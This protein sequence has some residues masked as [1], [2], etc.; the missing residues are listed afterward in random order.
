VKLFTRF[1][2]FLLIYLIS[3]LSI[4]FSDSFGQTPIRSDDFE[5][6]TFPNTLNWLGNTDKFHIVDDNGNKRL[7]L[8]ADNTTTKSYIAL[9]DTII[10]GSLEFEVNFNFTGLSSSNRLNVYF[11]LNSTNPDDNPSGY[12]LQA[13]ESGTSDVFKLYKVTNGSFSL[14]GSDTTLINNGGIYKVKID[15]DTTNLI[16]VAVGRSSSGVLN[17]FI[18][19]KDSTFLHSGSTVF[20]VLYTSTRTTS[21][22][23]DSIVL[24]KYNPFLHSLETISTQE[25]LLNF[26]DNIQ[27]TGLSISDFPLNPGAIT[28]DNLSFEGKS[29]RLHYT[30]PLP[31][32]NLNLQ[33][34][35]VSD[36]YA[37]QSYQ[38]SFS[39]TNTAIYANG[40]LIIN[41][42]MHNPPSGLVDFVEIKNTSN[43]VLTIGNWIIRDNNSTP[44]RL[45][46]ESEILAHDF[47][48]L[49]ADTSSLFDR[50]GTR[51]Y[52]Q[53]SS[54]PGFNNTSKDQIRFYT[55]SAELVD[56]L[57]YEP[58]WGT[59]GYSLERRS[60]N[61]SAIYR[62]NWGPSPNTIL[63]GSPGLANEIEADET[64]PVFITVQALARDTVQ[65][66][67]T[68][69][70]IEP[71]VSD[72]N[73][74][75]ISDNKTISEVII[76]NS[77]TVK[78][79]LSSLLEIN[80]SYSITVNHL[81]DLFGNTISSPISYNFEFIKAEIAT[82]NEIAI[83]EF[84]YDT[85]TGYTEFIEL[86]NPSNKVFDLINFTYNDN[87]GTLKTI[88]SESFIF[89]PGTY[90][91][92]VPNVSMLGFFPDAKLINMGSS[93][94]SLNNTGDHIVI[95]NA[96]SDLI[97][98]LSYNSTWGGTKVSLER[99]DFSVLG[100]YKE[101]WGNSPN[102]LFASMGQQNEVLV[103]ETAPQFITRSLAAPDTLILTFNERLST[104]SAT[105]LTNY[106]I[107]QTIRI[108]SV[109]LAE[110]GTQVR[111]GLNQN[112][113][114]NTIYTGSIF[115]ISDVFGNSISSTIEF[116][117]EYIQTQATLPGDVQITEFMFDPPTGYSEFIELKNTSD[118]YLDIANWTFNDNSASPKTIS[119]EFR[120][121]KPEEF[122]VIAANDNLNAFFPSAPIISMGSNFASLNNTSD[123][124]VIKNALG[125][126][127]D[128][129]AYSSS[130]G[131]TKFSL[132]RRS[133]EVSSR[134]KENW[135]N[136]PSALFASPGGE[137]TIAQDEIA[138]QL[139]KAYVLSADSILLNF[140]ERLDQSSSQ[141]KSNFT[142][143]SSV[144][145]DTIR[146]DET[147]TILAIKLTNPL[148]ENSS[149]SGTLTGLK[150]IF[151]NAISEAITFTFEFVQTQQSTYGDILITEFMFDPP[152][153][154]AEYIELKNIS[155][156]YVNLANW[157]YSDNSDS[158]K[159]LTEEFYVLKPGAYL[160]LSANENLTS[161]F[162][163]IPLLVLGSNFAS[164]NN[165]SDQIVI[166]NNLG[167]TLDSLE[168]S[169]SWGG[170]KLSLERRS[171][172]VSS[173]YQENWGN[174]LATLFGSPGAANTVEL[175]TNAPELI[176]IRAD[177][178][179][180]SIIFS[181]RLDFETAN[182]SN[183]STSLNRTET[184]RTISNQVI[185]IEF[186]DKLQQST[187]FS[188]TIGPQKDIFENESSSYTT[189]A[190]YVILRQAVNGDLFITE[191]VYKASD[192]TPEFIEIYNTSSENI[193]LRPFSISDSKET[194]KLS[195]R[196]G[197]PYY[198]E[199][200]SYLVITTDEGFT[201]G[202]LN[203]TAVSRLPSLNDTGSDAIVLK[204]AEFVADSV[205]Y[206]F[207]LWEQAISGQ[208]YERRALSALS[209]DPT[210]WG[211]NPERTH[212]AGSEN[213]VSSEIPSIQIEFAGWVE[214]DT[215][216]VVFNKFI[217]DTDS[218]KVTL[219]GGE[220]AN[221]TIEGN[222]ISFAVSEIDFSAE[223]AVTTQIELN[224]EILSNTFPTA[225]R[226]EN[227]SSKP[228]ILTEILFNPLNTDNV[229]Q[230]DFVEFFNPNTV[231]VQI[232][233]TL[234][235]TVSV[236]NGN[237][238]QMSIESN[239]KPLFLNGLSYG[240]IY[241]DTVS[242]F[243]SSRLS[244]YFVLSDTIKAFRVK[245]T[246]LS[247][248]S[249]NSA[250]VLKSSSGL[251]LDSVRYV[252]TWHNPNVADTRGRSLERILLSGGSNDP[253]NWSTSGNNLGGTPSYKNTLYL[254]A[255]KAE[256]NHLLISPNPFSPDL[257]G[258]EDNTTIS[259]NL[260]GSNY[261]IT[262]T[263]YDRYGR[264]I[265]N[266]AEQLVAGKQGSIIWDG[267]RE[268][269]T[270]NRIG[271]YLLVFKARDSTSGK[272][273]IK[274]ETIVIATKL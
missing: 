247:L 52:I 93:F 134:F 147:G 3:F 10:Y 99:R 86:F 135:G 1:S 66:V 138:P 47:V 193:D 106:S 111:L 210:S 266:L 169:S 68:E 186:A 161:F 211:L 216:I 181:E 70:V 130:W 145:I 127:L 126:T 248:S 250:L 137:N 46:A 34:P 133:T 109:I 227:S 269:G 245:R 61:L 84:M 131:G 260:D 166:K 45:P 241:A 218:I 75:S 2:L 259:W 203:R 196:T 143:S 167:Q 89:R 177:S 154:Y 39:F 229:H 268:D 48:V 55:D 96:E 176:E 57:E 56:S 112:L 82:F 244:N 185:T 233:T 95:R 18:S 71:E 148:T 258:F 24:S 175:D 12:A 119:D 103:D 78:L 220:L 32:G 58:F 219:S 83:S 157:T 41:E 257:D 198:I 97:D 202:H 183:I 129:L 173:L 44:Y 110:S 189:E 28:A 132:E 182:S 178:I 271:I 124:I 121:L 194:Q 98:S 125:Q 35:V 116:T 25:I 17:P 141:L 21:T 42:F 170:T 253:N 165:T 255:G 235:K 90:I 142:F 224:G 77:S 263:I 8:N 101:N 26:T 62:E 79:V 19:L 162:P 159:L 118:K 204:T 4:G 144:A 69:T 73:S 251:L 180:L 168:Y 67:F 102:A 123:Q 64:A 37:L 36:F 158:P 11:G 81:S 249:T 14:L 243:N 31:Y 262:A 151:G 163:D 136:S 6:S 27:T 200:A 228:L 60:A 117:I 232:P 30:T 164:L 29:I 149:Y 174:S 208:S 128:S 184:K 231:A 85:P 217:Q 171:E 65:I 50:F 206:S 190:N 72:I 153:G 226:L 114:E 40:D 22:S 9:P 156:K 49:A 212:S 225:L 94:S 237:E 246:S 265:R 222:R 13:G 273:V 88:S 230:G 63:R 100:S 254:E 23:F 192:T 5:S 195:F 272:E 172:S 59:S 213:S 15:R 256:E 209:I 223:E 105:L 92:L 104:S 191:F 261:L 152:T 139:I 33:I 238:T 150:D 240:I 205:I 108:T 264:K 239:G 179:S 187:T 270:S 199:A 234:M 160:V 120:V 155:D 207:P 122:L 53:L 51:N 146:L 242:E 107:D 54:F 7:Q 80:T 91:V 113:M 16:S 188:V 76:V 20:Q 197:F 74:Y 236:S 43:K 267:K 214:Q 221:P 115:G 38:T 274:K 215:F 140:S 87:S 201:V 252:D